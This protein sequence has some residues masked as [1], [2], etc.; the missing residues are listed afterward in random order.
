[1]MGDGR[2]TRLKHLRIILAIVLALSVTIAPIGSA[3]AALRATAAKADTRTADMSGMSD[4][5]KMMHGADKQ[6]A[7]KSDCP[8]CESNL[9]CSPEFCLSKCFQLL[10]TM[11]RPAVLPL[12]AMAQLWPVEADPPPDWCYRPPPPPPRT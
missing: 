10:G 9:A 12:V 6:P 11:P 2:R 1:M 4:C 3:W 8:C 7:K 5:E